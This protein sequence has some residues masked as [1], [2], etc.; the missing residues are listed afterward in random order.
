MRLRADPAF[1]S[2]G[3]GVPLRG[4]VP[5]PSRG[6]VARLTHAT[7]GSTNRLIETDCNAKQQPDPASS[8][9]FLLLAASSP[10][11][12]RPPLPLR[13]RRR[14]PKHVSRGDHQGGLERIERW[15]SGAQ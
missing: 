2:L 14:H 11:C 1:P 4:T 12:I 5:P 8:L 7:L 13:S 10:P 9:P 6:L 3:L 15:R